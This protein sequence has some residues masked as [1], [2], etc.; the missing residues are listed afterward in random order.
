[1]GH[2]TVKG[3]LSGKEIELDWSLLGVAFDTLLKLAPAELRSPPERLCRLY[4]QRRDIINL[5]SAEVAAEIEE[6]KKDAEKIFKND[7]EE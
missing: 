1:M 3:R 7:E 5:I 4:E 2:A 6:L